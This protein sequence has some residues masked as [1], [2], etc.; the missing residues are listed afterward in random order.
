MKNSFILYLFLLFCSI[1]PAIAQ[2]QGSEQI[3][4]QIDATMNDKQIKID[5]IISDIENFDL[6][7]FLEEQ[8][9]GEAIEGVEINVT[10]DSPAVFNFSFDEQALQEMMNDFEMPEF[11]A[12]PE[13]PAMPE[14]FGAISFFNGNKAFLG[15]RSEKE[16]GI[17]GVRI[18]EIIENSAAASSNLQSGDILLKVDEKTVESPNNLIEILNEYE[19]SDTIIITYQRNG[20][21]ESTTAILKENKNYKDEAEWDEYKENWEEWGKTYQKQWEEINAQSDSVQRSNDEEKAFLGVIINDM[22]QQPGIIIS[23]IIDES[24]A[25]KAGLKAGDIIMKI[26]DKELKNYE[27]LI[28]ALSEKKP[29]DEITITYTRDGYSTHTK[30]LLSKNNR[31]IIN[32]NKEQSSYFSEP[33]YSIKVN[34]CP[35]VSNCTYLSDKNGKRNLKMS[36]QILKEEDALQIDNLENASL[37]PEDIKFYPNPTE[38]NFNLE[39]KAKY[40]GDAEILIRN[41]DGKIVYE[42]LLQDFQGIYQKTM[43]LGTLPK[44]TYLVSITQNDFSA[45]KQIV[46]Q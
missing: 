38:G 19:P 22:D 41:V 6:N 23:E 28:S 33:S 29:G 16:K 39:F 27:E 15:V 8:G 37:N 32:W 35:A 45:T 3:H 10:D 24:P 44:G 2:N 7:T 1:H 36:I 14:Q 21:T 9:L 26:N 11:P 25:L 18:T 4:L 43:N 34:S 5:T 12:I 20:K 30:V 13:L 17:D 31:K 40:L 42:E 46:I